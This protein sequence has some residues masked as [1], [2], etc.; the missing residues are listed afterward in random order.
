[1]DVFLDLETGKNLSGQV[2]QQVRD[3]IADGRLRPGDRLPPS[4][5]LA[6]QLAVSRHTVTTAYGR[7]VAEGYTEGR[8]GGGSVVAATSPAQ[9]RSGRPAASLSPSRRFAGWSPY[10]HGPGPGS[11]CRF[12]LRAGMSDPALFP[13]AVWRRRVSAAIAADRPRYADPAGQ[14]RLRRAIAHWISR[15][16]SVI[17]D[18]D[19]V[20]ITCGAQH[21]IDLVA[22]VLLEPGDCVVVE[23]PGYVPVTR[24]LRCLGANVVCVPV[25]SQGLVVDLLPPTARLVYVTPSHQFPLGMTMS[26]QRRL[27]LLRWAERHDAAI[28]EDDYD[29]EFRYV[30]R[31][32]EPIHRLD[33]NGRVVYVGSF[34][35]TFSP[36]VRLGFAVVPGPLA[37]PIA[38]L[39][40]LIDWHPP[41]A[42]QAALAGFIEDGLLDKH[43][44]RSTRIY[45]QRR[46]II[47][48]AL[49]GPLAADLAPQT[50]SAGLHVAAVLRRGPGE[51]SVLQ[52]AA[53]HGIATTGLRCHY[54]ASRGQQG[55]VLGFGAISTADLPDA[56]Q[57]LASVLDT[58]EG[59][60]TQKTTASPKFGGEYDSPLG[61]AATGEILTDT[62]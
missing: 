60:L 38:A 19:A 50:A 62:G 23:E 52:A 30:D 25:D 15:S 7:L 42:T 61:F 4:R 37:S 6:E 12:D 27:A 2:Y 56:L 44:R 17:A 18:E 35:K 26:M 13:A 29:T 14:A 16:R 45:N 57:T 46:Q 48:A 31:P 36:S 22:R 9:S 59:G 24:L 40:Q 1:M 11:G 8:A 33:E 5:Q 54:Q 3:A 47:D 43:I 21:A 49:S 53:A 34:S 28:I 10:I 32:L 20:V 58:G 51:D 55:L 41:T 39:R